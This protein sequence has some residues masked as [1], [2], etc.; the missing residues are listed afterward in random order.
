MVG[1]S[2][3]SFRTFSAITAALFSD[4]V[5]RIRPTRLDLI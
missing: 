1:S 2:A 5:R 3:P 4:S